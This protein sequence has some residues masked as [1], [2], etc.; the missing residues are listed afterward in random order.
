MGQRQLR[1][2]GLSLGHGPPNGGHRLGQHYGHI[3]GQF[4]DIAVIVWLGF[5]AIRIC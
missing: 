3:G 4:W 2:D 1:R 5:K